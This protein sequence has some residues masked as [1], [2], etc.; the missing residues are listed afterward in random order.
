[1]EIVRINNPFQ[2]QDREVTSVLYINQTIEDI[3]KDHLEYLKE[4]HNLEI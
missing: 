3:L 4:K 1:M 2:R